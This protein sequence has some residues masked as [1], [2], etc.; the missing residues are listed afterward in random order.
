VAEALPIG[1]AEGRDGLVADD[2]GHVADAVALALEHQPRLVET[3]IA[4]VDRR[5]RPDVPAK[6]SQQGGAT[7]AAQPGQGIAI[8][9]LEQTAL[10]ELEGARGEFAGLAQQRWP[11]ASARALQAEVEQLLDQFNLAEARRHGL[12]SLA[13]DPLE[14][15]AVTDFVD[16]VRP[17]Q[18]RGHPQQRVDLGDG[19]LA[20]ILVGGSLASG[21]VEHNGD[22]LDDGT[23]RPNPVASARG[24]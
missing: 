12:V 15:V 18:Q 3:P 11:R 21:R 13:H 23:R 6:R 19:E 20:A 5:R 24:Q 1:V 2:G 9:R 16:P 7:R 17:R 10:D 14:D 4:N 8:E 22:E